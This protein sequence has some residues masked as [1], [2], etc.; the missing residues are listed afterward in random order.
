MQGQRSDTQLPG[1]TL[2]RVRQSQPDI[3]AHDNNFSCTCLDIL[4]Q[5]HAPPTARAMPSPISAVPGIF[6]PHCP[7]SFSQPSSSISSSPKIHLCRHPQPPDPTHL[8]PQQEQ[9][10]FIVLTPR[11]LQ[12][13]SQASS[14]NIC[15]QAPTAT[16]PHT[17]GPPSLLA[18]APLLPPSLS[19]KEQKEPS[20][21]KPAF[22]FT[23]PHPLPLHLH[24][25]FA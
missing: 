13:F 1:R 3:S 20:L 14:S 23:L 6:N 15:A 25:M 22:P 18:P 2:L 4:H 9:R 19:V 24:D 7:Q 5:L 17:P 11:Y 12:S 8:P 10:L 21:G 16:K